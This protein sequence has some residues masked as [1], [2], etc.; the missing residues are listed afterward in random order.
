MAGRPGTG[1]D[2]TVGH[3]DRGLELQQAP[4]AQGDVLPYPPL[5]TSPSEGWA[6][7][8]Y[9]TS[10]PWFYSSFPI[11]FPLALPQSQ[12]EHRLWVTLALPAEM[13]QGLPP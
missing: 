10:A 3:R 5:Q 4:P 1:G 9:F 7:Q 11:P 12:A 2:S 13:E 6:R 8:G